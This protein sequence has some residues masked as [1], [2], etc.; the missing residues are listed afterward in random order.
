MSIQQAGKKI[1]HF[2]LTKIVIGLLVV[3]GVVMLAQSGTRWLFD[4]LSMER[5]IR[6]LLI[7]LVT[8]VLSILSYAALFRV[9][10]KRTISEL[11]AK[12]IGRHLLIGIL[13]GALLQSLT[14]FVMYMNGGFKIISLNPV[15]FLL[16]ALGMSFTSAIFEEIM[17]RGIIFRIME[18]KLGS[19]IALVIS[20]CIFGALHLGNP[21][22]SLT[23]AIGLALQAG[24]F[25]AAAYI[26]SR[27]LWFPIAIHFAWNFT[28]GGIFGANT[29]GN[30]ISKSLLTTHIEG[31]D[32]YTGG[33]FG[34]EGSVQATVFCVLAT[35]VL[36]V[37]SHR[38]NKIIKPVWSKKHQA[39]ENKYAQV[40]P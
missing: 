29:S 6:G 22:S 14:I 32:W 1:L 9:Y 16:P 39:I 20:A 13:L 37:L 28:Q 26:Y 10:E 12:R 23:A 17:V 15:S 2:P 38:Q 8:A 11:S 21:N 25:L 40:V 3:V 27:N 30:S 24:T 35:I 4:Q 34:P 18:E 5:S 33:A 7:G 19:Y 36:L 31:E